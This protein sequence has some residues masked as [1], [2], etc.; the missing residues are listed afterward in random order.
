MD[1]AAIAV[2]AD[3]F[4]AFDGDPAAGKPQYW[5]ARHGTTVT[6]QV[7]DRDVR[8][9]NFVTGE[10]ARAAF[11]ETS[12]DPGPGAPQVGDTVEVYSRYGTFVVTDVTPI[13]GQGGYPCWWLNRDGEDV[14]VSFGTY[15]IVSRPEATS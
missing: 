12:C 2:T 7:E 15:E 3:E 11:A 1:T 10:L 5:V 8:T 14:D 13:S 9:F 4:F 6:D